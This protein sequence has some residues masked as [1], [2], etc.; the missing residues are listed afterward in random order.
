MIR[1]LTLMLC[2]ALTPLP[3][4]A[5]K[6]IAS[7]FP[8]GDV[9]EGEVGFSN[10]DMATDQLVEVFDGDGAKLGEARTDADGYF[11]YRPTAPV[12]HIFRADLGAGHVAEFEMTGE[13]VAAILGK[14]APAPATADPVV[15]VAPSG[16]PAP[17]L[18]GLST[19]D[20]AEIAR[21]VR[22]ETRP[23]RREIAAYKEHH[24]L[25]TVLG[26]IGYIFGLFGLG[27]YLAARRRLAA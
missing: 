26:G 15:E 12:R 19:A 14:A 6:V 8:S 10:G 2:L 5:H 3:A 17:A 20:K 21:I 24:D 4:A 9:I 22:D 25:Q 7:A 13:E 16:A 27:F 1:A 23:L 18:A 11:T